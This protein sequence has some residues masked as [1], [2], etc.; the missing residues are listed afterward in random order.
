[1]G[2]G[3]GGGERKGFKISNIWYIPW[4]LSVTEKNKVVRRM[5]HKR[6][7]YFPTEQSEKASLRETETREDCEKMKKPDL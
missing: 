7:E 4:R 3:G 6:K 2:R 5:K 1:M